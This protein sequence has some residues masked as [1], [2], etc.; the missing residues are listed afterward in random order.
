M[1]GC[2]TSCNPWHKRDIIKL[3][4]DTDAVPRRKGMFSPFCNYDYGC[5]GK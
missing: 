3:I 2:I 4:A 1:H 5:I